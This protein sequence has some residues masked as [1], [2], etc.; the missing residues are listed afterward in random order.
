[1]LKYNMQPLGLMSNML[2]HTRYLL[3]LKLDVFLHPDT[4]SHHTNPQPPH[5]LLLSQQPLSKVAPRPTELLGLM[6]LHTRCMPI[7]PLLRLHAF[8]HPDTLP[9][10]TNPYPLHNL[11]LSQQPLSKVAHRPPQL[12]GLKSNRL[13]HMRCM[14]IAHLLRSDM[15]LHPNTLPHHTNPQPPHHTLP[16]LPP[17]STKQAPSKVV[18]PKMLGKM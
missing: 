16:S 12:P 2:L 14:P 8:L 10:H 6:L 4:L 3:T 15:L 7:A 9:H 11:L 18:A 13:L 1:M 17:L 5:N